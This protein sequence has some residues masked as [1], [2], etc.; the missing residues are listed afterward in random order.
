MWISCCEILR[1]GFSVV[2]TNVRRVYEFA[3]AP[4]VRYKISSKTHL[5]GEHF[6]IGFKE[7]QPGLVLRKPG[8]SL[9]ANCKG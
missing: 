8:G 3:V 6:L 9:L 2:S 4:N 7:R 5:T 1:L